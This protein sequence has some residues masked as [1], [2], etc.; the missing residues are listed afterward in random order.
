M[1]PTGW[2]G[3][4]AQGQVILRDHLTWSPWGGGGTFAPKERVLFS[5]ER[6]R[7]LR[8]CSDSLSK[9]QNERFQE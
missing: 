7:I 4:H 6:G 1:V 8:G 9:F 3:S 5:Q 2:F